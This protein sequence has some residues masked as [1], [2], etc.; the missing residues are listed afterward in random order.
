MNRICLLVLGLVVLA[1]GRA[2]AQSGIPVTTEPTRQG[3]Q[4]ERRTMLAVRM[5]DQEQIV[6]DGRL[7]EPVW[8][9]AVPA[10][11][12]R[13]QEPRNGEPATEPTLVRIVYD[14]TTLYIGV[15]CLDDEPDRLLRFQRRRDEFLQADD[16][17]M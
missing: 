17:F 5:E 16:R 2:W 15:T 8:Q 10:G 6:L 1:N 4:P 7:D 12:F 9:R 14:R 11:D 13:Q 3:E